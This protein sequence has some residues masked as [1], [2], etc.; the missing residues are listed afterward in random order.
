MPRKKIAAANY[1]LIRLMN[2][3]ITNADTPAR[4]F[5]VTTRPNPD[6]PWLGWVPCTPASLDEV[7]FSAAGYFFARRIFQELNV[8]I[9]M[10]E[11]TAGGTHIEAWTPAA[12]VCRG[13]GTRRV[14]DRRPD[15]KGAKFHGTTI[16]TLYNGM[17]HP[18]VPFALRGVLWYQG[19]SNLIEKDGA[20]YTNK[21][22]ALIKSWRAAWGRE[23]PF[24]YV[25]LPPLLYSKRAGLTE[26]PLAEPVFREAQ[27]EALKLP[28]TQAWSSR[29]TSVI[30]KNMHPPRKKEVGERLARWALA[31]DYGRKDIEPSG[32][33]YQYR[34]IEREGFKAVL[35]F[36][37]VDG[38]L[39]SRDG[40]PLSCFTR[41]PE[42]D[43]KFFPAAANISG[44]AVV[45]TCPDVKEP[46]EV[47]FAFDEAADSNFLQQ[48]R[49]A[50][51]T[52][53]HG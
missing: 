29:P 6:Y 43:G 53:P 39:V 13:P 33:T 40:Q 31:R 5:S 36:D 37:H 2:I 3:E 22:A 24:Y 27:A 8:P 45:I 49:P 7:K 4:D 19:E 35:H 21:M 14:R 1:P 51:R 34:S 44:D 16:C 11:A 23:F 48:G 18:L 50:R 12:G 28:D 47:R 30:L 26:V 9:G 52:V 10:M 32:P 15:A 20:I 38:G 46:K 25:Q 41:Q 42:P 17:I